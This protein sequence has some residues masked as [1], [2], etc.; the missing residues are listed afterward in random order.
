VKQNIFKRSCLLLSV[1]LISAGGFAFAQS[2]SS[3]TLTITTYY[4]SPYGVYR[5][6]EVKRGMAVGDIT[7]GPLASMDNLKSGQLYIN[8]SVV[9]NTLPTTP[10]D[11]NGTA[12]Q[13]I[14]VGGTDKMIKYHDGIRWVNATLTPP[15]CPPGK[16]CYTT[17][18]SESCPVNQICRPT[19]WIPPGSTYVTTVTYY[20]VC[21]LAPQICGNTCTP[22]GT[23]TC[24]N[25]SYP[26]PGSPYTFP[27]GKNPPYYFTNSVVVC[28]Q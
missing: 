4:P 11:S 24:P 28:I 8:N 3:E 6:L 14:Y 12:G 27:G 20:S 2:N 18:S 21:C 10:A 19:N 16:Q 13:V 22:Q 25:G 1:L 9:L 23:T 15:P 7:K 17:G 5:N 26:A